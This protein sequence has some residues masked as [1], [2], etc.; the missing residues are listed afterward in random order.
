VQFSVTSG[1]ISAGNWN[2]ADDVRISSGLIY[3][4]ILGN[5][6]R[7]DLKMHGEWFGMPGSKKSITDDGI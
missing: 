6:G 1:W 5:G 4:Y 2:N 7:K 3:T